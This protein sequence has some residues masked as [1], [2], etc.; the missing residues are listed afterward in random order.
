MRRMTTVLALAASMLLATASLAVAAPS[1]SAACYDWDNHGAHIVEYVED[2]KAAGGGA[3]H[4]GVAATPGA[5]FC[6]GD[7]N[8]RNLPARP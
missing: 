4:F 1:D 2:G 5:S 8:A 6:Q 7:N 3:A